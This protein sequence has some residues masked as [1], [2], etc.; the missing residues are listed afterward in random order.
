MVAFAASEPEAMLNV[1]HGCELKADQSS[2]DE[3]SPVFPIVTTADEVAVDEVFAAKESAVEVVSEMVGCGR[4]C[5]T[6]YPA[7][8]DHIFEKFHDGNGAFVEL[9]SK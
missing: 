9:F 2:V 3:T 7:V 6:G 4:N 8:T 1:S 5:N